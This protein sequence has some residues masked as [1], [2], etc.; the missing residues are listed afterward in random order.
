ML[1]KLA[2]II[3]IPTNKK[4]KMRKIHVSESPD[5]VAALEHLAV[6][7]PGD[8]WS[9]RV[10]RVKGEV[11]CGNRLYTLYTVVAA[12]GAGRVRES[13]GDLTLS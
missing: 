1:A 13:P 8:S 4:K 12:V 5:G 11:V 6:N 7:A 9:V 10:C 2:N 3:E